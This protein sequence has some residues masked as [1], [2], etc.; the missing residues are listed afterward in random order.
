M[1]ASSTCEPLRSKPPWDLESYWTNGKTCMVSDWDV[2]DF[3]NRREAEQV[4]TF[5]D[6]RIVEVPR[7]DGRRSSGNAV[8]CFLDQAD[9]PSHI[10]Q[11]AFECIHC[12][13][14]ISVCILQ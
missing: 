4:L 3:E 5:M 6:P 7:T 12:L 8:R 2:V 14:S 10:T 9:F 1:M 13:I 11:G